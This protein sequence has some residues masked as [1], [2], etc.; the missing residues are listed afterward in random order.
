ME[1]WMKVKNKSARLLGFQGS[2]LSLVPG[3]SEFVDDDFAKVLL[4]DRFFLHYLE[5]GDLEV[6][7]E[8]EPA[9]IEEKPE[10]V[11]AVQVEESTQ[12]K[13]PRG[14]PRKIQPDSIAK[15]IEAHDVEGGSDGSDPDSVQDGV[16]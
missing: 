10:A 13:R 8:K 9:R 14:R 7:K 4:A 11:A 2:R 16:S 12:P 1:V 15:A 3:Q 5:I 6:T